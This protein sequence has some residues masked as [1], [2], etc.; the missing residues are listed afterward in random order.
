M[1]V[2]APPRFG[3]EIVP[4]RERISVRLSGELDVATVDRVHDCVRDL[5]ASGWSD[6]AIDV[7]H[8]DFIDSTGLAMLVWLC[9]RAGPGHRRPVISGTSPALERLVTVSGLEHVLPRA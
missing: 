5:W 2:L 3:L 6:V 4:D 9:D 7:T 1:R 8:I